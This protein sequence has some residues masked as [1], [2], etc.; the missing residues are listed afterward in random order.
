MTQL[1]YYLYCCYKYYFKLELS[2]QFTL[3]HQFT[4]QSLLNY[5]NSGIII[6]NILKLS[7]LLRFF[8]TGLLLE[9]LIQFI[10]FSDNLMYALSLMKLFLMLFFFG[11]IIGC[12]WYLVGMI[13]VQEQYS[14]NWIEVNELKLSDV[15]GSYIASLYFVL[16]I[17]LSFHSG[18]YYNA[19]NWLW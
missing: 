3:S 16:H 18:I 14:S 4:N 11:H 2:Q 19:H 9:K 17:Y 6:F 15:G 8:K 7:F 5:D 12:I 1:R 10:P 13:G